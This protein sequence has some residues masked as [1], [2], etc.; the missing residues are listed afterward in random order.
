MLLT[1]CNL[2]GMDGYQLAGAWRAL[3]ATQSDRLRLPIVAMTAH[4]FPNANVHCLESGMDD[5]PGKPILLRP[6][7]EKIHAWTREPEEALPGIEVADADIEANPAAE[8]S[9]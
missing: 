2:S 7:Q 1:D 6:L 4:I 5:Y 3:E 9:L 8:P